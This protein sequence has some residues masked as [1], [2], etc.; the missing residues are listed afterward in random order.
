[1]L[2]D[3]AKDPIH[4][5]LALMIAHLSQSQ[6][7]AKVIGTIGIAAGTTQWTLASDLDRQRRRAAGKYAA[8]RTENIRS[9]HRR[10]P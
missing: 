5:V 6:R 1:M 9:I 3:Q 10:F 2:F 8:P 7:P 4:Q